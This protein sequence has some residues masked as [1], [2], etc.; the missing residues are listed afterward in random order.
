M[1]GEKYEFT[2]LSSFSKVKVI[3]QREG[4]SSRKKTVEWSATKQAA[5][6]LFEAYEVSD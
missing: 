2:S 5:P 6:L 3:Q 1:F 4:N